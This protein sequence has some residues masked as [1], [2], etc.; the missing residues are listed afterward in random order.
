MGR[1]NP[2]QLLILSFLR[3]I[4]P[5]TAGLTLPAATGGPGRTSLIDSLFTATGAT[6]V[7]GLAGKDAPSHFSVFGRRAI[8]LLF[9]AGGLVIMTFSALFAAMLGRRTGFYGT[10]VICRTLDKH[11]VP[12]LKKLISYILCITVIAETVQP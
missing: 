3:A 11:S 12:G 9:Q 7:T 6:C 8:F 4:I 10:D 5:G 1:L 2:P